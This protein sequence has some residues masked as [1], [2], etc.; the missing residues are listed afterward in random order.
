MKKLLIALSFF[1]AIAS[2]S[3]NAS[4]GSAQLLLDDF[5][6]YAVGCAAD[7][8]DQLVQLLAG[9][10]AWHGVGFDEVAGALRQK[11]VA[12]HFMRHNH[13]RKDLF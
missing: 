6:A 13:C 11:N 12:N 1:L 7:E 8:F 5:N 10:D 3:T 4:A 9:G 2:F